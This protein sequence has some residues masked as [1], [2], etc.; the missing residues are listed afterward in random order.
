MKFAKQLVWHTGFELRSTRKRQSQLQIARRLPLI[1]A[2]DSNA[3]HR[4][5]HVARDSAGLSVLV[6]VAIGKVEQAKIVVAPVDGGVYVEEVVVADVVAAEVLAELE[7]MV[8]MRPGE[9]VDE[10]VLGDVPSLRKLTS[11]RL[12]AGEIGTA[13]ENMACRAA[14]ATPA[15][16]CWN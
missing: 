16:L 8:A 14:S 7:G 5:W 10:L 3:P 13:P 15:A 2:V 6:G 1:L 4:D 12:K 9:I 11:Q